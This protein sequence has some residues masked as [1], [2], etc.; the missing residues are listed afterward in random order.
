MS[1]SML[2]G[3]FVV[4]VVGLIIVFKIADKR[5][6]SAGVYPFST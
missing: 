1:S 3:M 6:R 5:G 4:Y 2:R